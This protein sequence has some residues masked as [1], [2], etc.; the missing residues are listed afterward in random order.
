MT[1]DG[2]EPT[3]S[4]ANDL[5]S[6]KPADRKI[7]LVGFDIA[8]S[9]S[10]AGSLA[11]HTASMQ[12]DDT[13]AE[14][15]TTFTW[16]GSDNTP[17]PKF[18]NADAFAKGLDLVNKTRGDTLWCSP[19]PVDK[20]PKGAQDLRYCGYR[21]AGAFDARTGALWLWNTVNR[22]FVGYTEYKTMSAKDR[23]VFG[24]PT[25]VSTWVFN[26]VDVKMHKPR[27]TKTN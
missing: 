18:W 9:P 24:L 3:T 16:G 11:A 5:V 20:L 1:I 15:V 4:A 2:S 26:P 22:C 6:Q 12:I 21:R 19:V 25:N 27:T 7:A 14:V 13:P 10:V 8:G 23:K 17:P